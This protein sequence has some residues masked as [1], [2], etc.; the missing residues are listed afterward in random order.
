[1]QKNDAEKICKSPDAQK[2]RSQN[3][4]IGHKRKCKKKDQKT[5]INIRSQRI[6][7]MIRTKKKT[8]SLEKVK[9]N[10]KNTNTQ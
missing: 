9:F 10:K 5:I 7:Q 8:K 1:M 6:K 4:L 2:K 3:S